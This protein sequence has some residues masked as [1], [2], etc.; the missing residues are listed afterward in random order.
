MNK[1]A[2]FVLVISM[3]ISFIIYIV[4]TRFINSTVDDANKRGIEEYVGAIRLAYADSLFK[5]EP[6]TDIDSLNID[7]TT[8]VS[9][10]EKSISSDGIIELHGCRVEDS[11]AKYNYV[12]DKV[13]K[14]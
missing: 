8:K 12:N 14:E 2:F 9:C 11:K 13:G 1:K 3:A 5:G 10:E 6:I 7:I 4:I